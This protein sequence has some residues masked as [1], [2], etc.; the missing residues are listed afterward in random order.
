MYD[1]GANIGLYSLF[2]ARHLNGHCKVFAFEP[3]ALNY[4]KLSKNIHLNDLS[5]VVIP[6]CLVITDQL[7]F[8]IFHLHPENFEK[9]VTG[10]A[11]AAGSALHSFGVVEDYSGRDFQP[12]HVQGMVGVSLDYLWQSWDVDFP[13][14]I[15]IDVDGLEDKI[16]AGATQ[17]L[18]DRRLRSV[19]I[20]VSDKDGTAD[21]ILQQLLQAGFLRVTDFAA[22][23][24]E[25]LKGTPYEGSVNSVF[26]REL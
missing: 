13:N 19:L 6:C 22:H 2:A 20:E 1:V 11:L 25:L 10:Q 16:M 3:E 21:P 24:S 14:H 18:R 26:I 12:I 15:K 8:D 23:S 9:M 4:S 7:C 17:T 5:G